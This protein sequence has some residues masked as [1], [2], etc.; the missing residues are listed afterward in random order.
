MNIRTVWRVI[1]LIAAL[2]LLNASVT[3]YNVWPTPAIKWEH[4]LSV[5]LAAVILVL[6]VALRRYGKLSNRGLRWLSVFWMLMI[7]GHYGDVTAPGLYGRPINLFWD[8]RHLAAVGGMLAEAAS[9][10]IVIAAAAGTAVLALLLY[11][12]VRFAVGRLNEGLSHRNE[13][14]LVG[15][16][17][18]ILIV[19]WAGQQA[20]WIYLYDIVFSYPVSATYWRQARLIGTAL[21]ARAG[22]REILP[23]PA[24]DSDLAN[25]RGADVYLIFME[26]YGAVTYDRPEFAAQLVDSRARFEADVHDTGRRVVSA[27]VESPT[28]GGS[29]WLAHV[30]LITGVET[31]DED[32]N[33]LLMS[34]KR[35]TMLS[36]FARQGYRTLALMPGLRQ[37]WPEGAFYGFNEIYGFTRLDYHGPEFGWWA[38]PDQYSMARLDALEPASPRFLFFPTS[39]TH[40]PFGP[41]APYQPD[42]QR[43][44]SA[45]PFDA[46]ELDPAMARQPDLLNLSPSYLHALSYSFQT[47][48]GY[49][50][51]HANR[52]FVMILIGDHQPPAAVSGANASWNVPVHIVASRPKI[53]ESLIAKGFHEGM[54]PPRQAISPMHRLLPTLL[55]VFGNPGKVTL[56]ATP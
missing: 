56:K 11:I 2:V 44:L 55:E 38:I 43:V 14:R 16:L 39:G 21:S 15:A 24:V 4:D 10:K 22:N 54:T 33:V 12:V 30:S 36:T 45:T 47:F 13:S 28:F 51:Q 1:G 25:I 48:G 42:W 27:L 5:E 50:H 7:I 29:S 49:L 53:I 6:A 37:T 20:Q 31:R 19:I 52:D 9:R 35:K 40:T 23:T 3:F 8:V 17:A 32:T 34:R 26:S 46:A 18:A 41:T